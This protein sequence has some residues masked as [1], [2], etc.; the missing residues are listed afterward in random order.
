MQRLRKHR[1][2]DGFTLLETVV[3]M[4]VLVFGVLSLSTIFTAGLQSS[5]KSQIQFIAQQKA[6]E[7]LESIFTARDTQILSFAQINNVS[8]GGVFKDGPQ[9]LLN[10]GPDG[11]VGTADDDTTQPDGITIGPGPDN[12]FGTADDQVI[13]LNPWM[14]RTI[15]FTPVN[16][17]PNLNQITVT[18]NYTYQ[19]QS[20]TFVLTSYISNYS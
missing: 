17:T 8:V 6:Q 4:G 16:G 15:A 11:I 1:K 18:I 2:Q 19:G 12:V 14:T 3:A 20:G 13:P 5:N 10:P 9:P 7:A